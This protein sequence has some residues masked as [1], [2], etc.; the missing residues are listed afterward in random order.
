[1]STRRPRPPDIYILPKPTA[2]GEEEE[3]AEG[4]AMTVATRHALR[5]HPLSAHLPLSPL[6]AQLEHLLFATG[7]RPDRCPALPESP[8]GAVAPKSAEGALRVGAYLRFSSHM[9]SD[10]YSIPAQERAVLQEAQARGN[11]EV[12]CYTEPEHSAYGEDL[13]QRPMFL[14]MLRDALEGRLDVVVVHKLDRFSRRLIV[15]SVALRALEQCRV[16]FFSVAERF[17][18]TTPAGFMQ[19]HVMG[20]LAEFYSR[21]LGTEIA[22]GKRERVE[23]DGL[24]LGRTPF[25][26]TKPPLPP[27]LETNAEATVKWL[28]KAAPI[29][30]DASEEGTWH[31]LQMLIRLALDGRSDVE[32]ADVLNDPT[33]PWSTYNAGNGHRAG[34][35]P[36]RWTKQM[37]Q[38]VRTNPFYRPYSA[39]PTDDDLATG[40]GTLVHRGE[41]HRG[42]HRPAVLLADWQR[43]QEGAA[44]RKGNW[45]GLGRSAPATAGERALVRHQGASGGRHGLRKEPATA[46]SLGI[47]HTAEFRGVAVCASCGG[48][49]YVRRSIYA[50]HSDAQTIY[51]RYCCAADERTGGRDREQEQGDGCV[52]RDVGRWA[53]VSDVR[54]AFLAWADEHLAPLAPKWQAVARGVAEDLLAGRL[55]SDGSTAVATTAAAAE[56]DPAVVARKERERI[57][58]ALECLRADAYDGM[59]PVGEYRR[60]KV[61]LQSQLAALDVVARPLDVRREEL[62]SC[63]GILTHVADFWRSEADTDERIALASRLLPPGGLAVRCLGKG[64]SRSPGHNFRP[65]VADPLPPSCALVAVTL[66]PVYAEA[67]LVVEETRTRQMRAG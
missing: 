12:V 7:S 11:W 18:C 5:T 66:R 64:Q 50:P 29:P 45:H 10:G 19:A 60:R 21:N 58:R 61:A 14:A 8:A 17:D 6:P 48:R 42:A 16:G 28:R 67:L 23:R 1:M 56:R 55:R 44:R 3:G 34:D 2:E 26:Y 33:H 52:C 36:R 38:R 22:K 30:D 62:V 24:S 39:A 27:G 49:L 31:G 46:P 54:D 63:A 13:T 43:M 37:V 53:R 65:D 15:T 57:E 32:I 47:P 41:Q 35:G 4:N 9:Q 25:G 20:V 51:E 59:L 40:H